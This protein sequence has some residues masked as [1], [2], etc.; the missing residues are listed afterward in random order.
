M[1]GAPG[2][3]P[4]LDPMR[5]M[6]MEM[7]MPQWGLPKYSLGLSPTNLMRA[8]N[9]GREVDELRRKTIKEIL[10][11]SGMGGKPEG[12]KSS[13]SGGRSSSGSGRVSSAGSPSKAKDPEA[14]DLKQKNAQAVYDKKLLD[15]EKGLLDLEKK[16]LEL[17]NLPDE[18]K[19]EAE[20][21]AYK[22]IEREMKWFKMGS[23]LLNDA[24]NEDRSLT[25]SEIN[26]YNSMSPDYKLWRQ[27][28]REEKEPGTFWDK[29]VVPETTVQGLTKGGTVPT[30]DEIADALRA[31]GWTEEQITRYL[32]QL[33]GVQ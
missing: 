15:Y 17:A 28:F 29:T 1:P 7:L 10:G 2:G 30:R 19:R 11:L 33:V 31:Q 14:E 13:S 20:D 4:P 32:N 16:K 21:R 5:L 3:I 12:G 26:N 6:A 27:R 23:D 24:G 8:L 18:L 9:L 25:A 22:G